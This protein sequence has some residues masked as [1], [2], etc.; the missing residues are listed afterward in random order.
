[1]SQLFA[2]GGQSI[3]VSASLAVLLMNIQDCFPLGL[4]GL[5]SL[6]Q[7]FFPTPQLRSIN[8]S[9]FSLLYV[10]LSHPC[11]TTEKTIAFTT[12]TFVGKVMSLL[13]NMLSRLVISFLSRSKRI[14]ILWL[15]SP[16]TVILGPKKV[17]SATVST[18]CM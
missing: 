18:F 1:M 11:M 14:L 17:K 4:T 9:V 12:W 10:Q 6:Q 13:F 7:E 3:G 2:S 8:S 5:I 16:S 15:Q